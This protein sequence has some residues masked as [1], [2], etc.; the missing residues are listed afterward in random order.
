MTTS[1]AWRMACSTARAAM[2][3][4]AS[5]GV[6]MFSVPEVARKMPDAQTA[7]VS[8]T[9]WLHARPRTYREVLAVFQEAGRGLAAAHREGL[10]HGDFKPD[11]V[12]VDNA[13]RVRVLDFGLA[14]AQDRDPEPSAAPR[15]IDLD[16]RS[17]RSDT[18]TG[19]P[20]YLSPEQFDGDREAVRNSAIEHAFEMLL[21]VL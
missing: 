16:G 12:L 2:S 10:A 8:L 11:N 6:G 4:G 14:F 13:G 1:Q 18:L 19:T 15:D 5:M 20:A 21:R 9:A 7:G 3:G 17:T